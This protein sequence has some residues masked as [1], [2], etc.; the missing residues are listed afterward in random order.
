M[1]ILA[2]FWKS[3]ACGQTVLPDRSVLIV[4]KLVKMPKCDILSNFQTMCFMVQATEI[5]FVCKRCSIFVHQDA[6]K[7]SNMSERKISWIFFGITLLLLPFLCAYKKFASFQ[8]S[9]AWKLCVAHFDPCLLVC[10]HSPLQKKIFRNKEHKKISF[11]RRRKKLF[12][13]SIWCV[14]QIK[15]KIRSKF[16]L[17]IQEF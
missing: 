14:L 2:S 15:G 9:E 16:T 17:I 12:T 5:F 10:S 6:V 13:T 3:E 11:E 7:T 4:Q 8:P 1:S